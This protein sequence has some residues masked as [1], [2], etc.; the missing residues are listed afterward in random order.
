[1]RKQ[2]REIK[3]YKPRY[4]RVKRTSIYN[5][6]PICVY[7]T[8]KGFCRLYNEKCSKQKKRLCHDFIFAG[9]KE[10]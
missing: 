1:M 3:K 8:E 10:K 7:E 5:R 6:E 9:W 4:K 2:K